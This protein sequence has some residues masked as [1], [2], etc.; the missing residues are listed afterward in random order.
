MNAQEPTSRQRTRTPLL[1]TRRLIALTAALALASG[2]AA[3]AGGAALIRNLGSG[4]SSPN[5]TTGP[6]GMNGTIGGANTMQY[7]Y[8][9]SY[10]ATLTADGSDETS[11]GEDINASDTDANVA[12][13]R[14]GGT[15]MV[16]NGTLAKTG[17]GSNDD[18]CNFY[19]TN[20]IALVVGDGST[21]IIDGSELTA[22]STGSNG[23]FATDSGTALVNDTT[24]TTTADNS[25]GL[26]ATY[27]GTILASAVTADTSG[28]HS[29]TAATDR[30][31]GTVSI[32]DSTLTTAGSGSPLLYS[33]GDIQASGVT[34]T[35][36]G[37]Q[38]AGMEGL[39]TILINDSTLES[40]NT[41]T[42][43]S[44]PIANGVIIY[45][46]TSGD[47]EAATGEHATFQ[48]KDSTLTSAIGSGSMFYV[49]NTTADVVLSSTALDFDTSAATLLQASGND[50]NGW[51]QA[52]SN[53]AT[54]NFTGRGQ[55]LAGDVVADTISTVNLYLLDGTTWTGAASITDNA[56]AASGSTS[57]APITVNVDGTSTWIVT[58]DTTISALNVADGGSVVDADG[59][60]V[61]IIADGG[62]VVKG[63]GDVTVTVIGGYTTTVDETADTQ[64]SDDITDRSAFD[65]QFGTSTAWSM[66]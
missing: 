16:S 34:G 25:R 29:A 28:D 30:G 35:A 32:T 40:T 64:L 4:S 63:T 7:D 66:A 1:A 37:S 12:L 55:T 20:A 52:G 23:V 9:G 22:D 5:G 6:G 45:Q 57:D 18:N 60:T 50:A 26:D 19:G 61:T 54:V 13:A 2:L 21:A 17:D 53:G 44:D 59:D 47:A 51:G 3:G 38:I 62:T 41:G 56:S 15:L 11:D 58:D 24:I 65:E 43:G 36:S 42:T 10:S 33:T 27:G 49:T 14:N 48:A 31:G 8:S 46:S 39:N